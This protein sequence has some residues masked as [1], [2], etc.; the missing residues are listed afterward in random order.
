MNLS[1]LP[2]CLFFCGLDFLLGLEPVLKLGAGFVTALNVE[3]I[4]S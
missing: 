1:R 4:G 3:F 2:A